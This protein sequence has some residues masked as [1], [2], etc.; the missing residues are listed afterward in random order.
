MLALQIGWMFNELEERKGGEEK[1]VAF[2]WYPLM[3]A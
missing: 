2:Q 3:F 1:I